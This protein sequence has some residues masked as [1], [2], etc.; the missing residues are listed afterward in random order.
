MPPTPS[1]GPLLVSVDQQG[2]AEVFR[3]IRAETDGKELRKELSANLRNAARPVVT[4]LKAAAQALPSQGL[5]HAQGMPLRQAIARSIGTDLRTTG[6]AA[7]I[8]LRAKATP[9]VRGFRYAARAMN[10]GSFR[11]RVFGRDVWVT[12]TGQPRWFDNVTARNRE[13]FRDAVL[14]AVEDMRDRIATRVRSRT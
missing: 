3:A 4:D 5:P 11:H 9:N 8:R 6:K 14:S 7:G 13:P 12:Q 2:F 10:K 1:S